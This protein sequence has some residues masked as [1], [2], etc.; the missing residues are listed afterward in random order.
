MNVSVFIETAKFRTAGAL[1]QKIAEGIR[2]RIAAVAP[3]V[4][5]HSALDAGEGRRV[6]EFVCT[7]QSWRE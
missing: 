6:S 1:C 7:I 3:S 5:V 2:R 4:I